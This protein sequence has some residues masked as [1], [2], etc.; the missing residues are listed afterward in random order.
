MAEE[1]VGTIIDSENKIL[2]PVYIYTDSNSS[3]SSPTQTSNTTLNYSI[4]GVVQDNEYK[5][6]VISPYG[7]VYTLTW[8]F[9]A[10]PIL[11]NTSSVSDGVNPLATGIIALGGY[12]TLDINYLNSSD[13][14]ISG[15]AVTCELST[16]FYSGSSSS[17]RTVT[18]KNNLDIPIKVSFSVHAYSSSLSAT[19]SSTDFIQPQ[20]TASI[21]HYGSSYMNGSEYSCSCKVYIAL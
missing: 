16:T 13:K 6:I 20:S 7:N 5:G 4:D 9:S 15:G 21:R 8:D 1:S 17:G 19:G 3:T 12:N 18:V 2:T 14:N 10:D 11:T